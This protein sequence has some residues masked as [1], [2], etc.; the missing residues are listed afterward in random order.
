MVD[1]RTARTWWT[2]LQRDPLARMGMKRPP[3]HALVGLVL[4]TGQDNDPVGEAL[5]R[6]AFQRA[7][8]GFARSRGHVVSGRV[9]DRGITLLPD[10]AE[11]GGRARAHLVDLATRVAAIARRFELKLHVGIALAD[12]AGSLVS[13]RTRSV[14]PRRSRGACR[15]RSL[16]R[17]PTRRHRPCATSGPACRS[18]V[19]EHPSHLSVRFE[20]Y[21]EAVLSHTGYR[22]DMA[23]GHLQIGLERLAEPLLTTGALDPKSF[24]EI[25][26]TV[27][28]ARGPDSVAE[29]VLT[30]R[31][32]V[33]DI[34]R[35]IETP[36][37]AR[38]ERST[39]RALLFVHEHLA[40]P[41]SL[42]QSPKI[43]GFAPDYFRPLKEEEGLSFGR[44]VQ[45]HR[46]ER[47]KQL[48]AGTTLGVGRVA[49]LS[50][51]RSRT[52]FQRLFKES[53]GE[54]PA[55]YRRF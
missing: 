10:D 43:A 36:T 15:W 38:Q 39:R 53:T 6:I 16:R 35:A 55:H 5:R 26:R 14:P 28:V 19:E 33:V 18:G 44:Y 29:L 46:L 31:R 41:L 4:G 45:K 42:V 32:I 49:Q 11:A 51:F 21:L 8:V 7:C 22:V 2:G 23:R 24:D 40:K 12:K 27:D 20:R 52:N 37:V 30:Y 48:L 50:G 47:A 17:S 3:K 13:H 25:C 1:E 34:E 54:T 9:G